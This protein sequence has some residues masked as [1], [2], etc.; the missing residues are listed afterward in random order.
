M[1]DVTSIP[2]QHSPTDE[3]L[4]PSS[5]GQPMA[6]TDLHIDEMMEL[7]A[8]LRHHFKPRADQMYVAS[9]LF[10]YYEQG[11]PRAVFAPDVFVARGVAQRQRKTY[12]LWL[13]GPAPVFVV[14]ITSKSTRLED[15]GNKKALCEMLGV[16]EYFLYDPWGEYLE[17]PLQGFRLAADGYK[18]IAVDDT[19]A[20]RADTLGLS[21]S[22]DTRG[23]L[24]VRDM[25]T[26][27]R[28][29]RTDEHYERA[30]QAS[31]E[32][33]RADEAERRLAEALAELERRRH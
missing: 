32:K 11:N 14:E 2:E 7:K 27:E 9:N 29:L 18:A 24:E 33:A 30:Q 8:M 10:V 20:L 5:D 3:D 17:P 28:L 19:G 31:Q 22:L 23:L 26:G 21:L 25:E 6:E 12:K 15:K 1:G 13:D 4:Y 16:T